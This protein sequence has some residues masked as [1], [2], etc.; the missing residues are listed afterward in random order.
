[1]IICQAE[2][3]SAQWFADRAGKPTASQFGRIITPATYKLSASRK[4]YI[5][6][7]V[8]ERLL[9]TC[10]ETPTSNAMERGTEMEPEAR[11]AFE[12]ATG[13]SVDQVGLC[14]TDDSKVGASPDGWNND[15][16]RGLELKCPELQKHMNNLLGGVM[17]KDHNAQVQGCIW[18]TGA[19]VWHFQSYYPGLP[20]LIVDIMP[21][22]AYQDALSEHMPDF[23]KE[24]DDT[25]ARI[26]EKYGVTA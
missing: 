12:I 11:M 5:A 16:K 21:D 18:V 4:A 26:R 17:P 14:L 19:D 6:Q 1:M 22:Q 20:S 2:Q 9:G 3:G 8:G 15:E 25:E 10:I 23:L 24:L 7:L 13:Y